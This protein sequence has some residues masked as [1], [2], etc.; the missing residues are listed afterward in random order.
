MLMCINEGN[1]GR[2]AHRDELT[3][4][5]DGIFSQ[6]PVAHWMDLLAGTIPIAPVNGLGEALDNPWLETITMRE[7]IAHP[8]RE[9]LAVL[10]N[11]LKLDGRRLP[12]RAAPL[13]GADSEAILGEVGYDAAEI[14]RLRAAGVI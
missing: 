5:L 8:D 12:N 11:P 1:P 13:L 2:L 3:G 4:V 10:A 7:T 6:A 9:H 14:A